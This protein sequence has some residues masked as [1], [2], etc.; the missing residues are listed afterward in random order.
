MQNV[1][2]WRLIVFAVWV[3]WAAF[4]ITTLF[5]YVMGNHSV[6]LK[7]F[8]AAIRAVATRERSLNINPTIGA[9]LWWWLNGCSL[10]ATLLLARSLA[11][12][13]TSIEGIAVF[14][15]D[16]PLLA[17]YFGMFVL[18]DSTQE[19]NRPNTQGSIK[20]SRTVFHWTN[21]VCLAYYPVASVLKAIV[22]MGEN[23]VLFLRELWEEL[24]IEQTR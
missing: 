3:A 22:W 23:F 16:I 24:R 17:V 19:G 20:L 14:L 5:N 10:V 11:G 7:K 21:P 4:L 18:L 1:D 6:S 2:I 15:L 12:Y 13:D 8:L 9:I